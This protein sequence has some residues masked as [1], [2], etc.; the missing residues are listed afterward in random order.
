[1][2]I[3]VPS[4]RLTATPTK[5]AAT[6][7][8]AACIPTFSNTAR[9]GT[10]MA[11]SVANSSRLSDTERAQHVADEQ[12][13]DRKRQ[14]NADPVQCRAG[15]VGRLSLLDEIVWVRDRERAQ[16][17]YPLSNKIGPD[18][19]DDD[20]VHHVADCGSLPHCLEIHVDDRVGI[21]PRASKL[22]HSNHV[23][24]PPREPQAVPRANALIAGEASP[25]HDFTGTS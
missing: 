23:E 2:L 9:A 15:L 7:T 4:A 19:I 20:Q 13:G 6:V 12:S 8:S 18:G 17:F 22:A 16:P 5:L 21:Q 3:S 14:Q 25:H 24:V 1:M 10:P 11:R